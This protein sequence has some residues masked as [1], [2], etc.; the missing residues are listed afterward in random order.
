MPLFVCLLKIYVFSFG[1]AGSLLLCGPSVAV[2]CRG[3]SVVVRGF[4]VAV[5]SLVAEHGLLS[6][7]ASVGVA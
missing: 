5:A 1:C 3:C 6:A 2:M 4:L 7:R